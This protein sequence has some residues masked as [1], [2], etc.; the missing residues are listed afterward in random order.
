MVLVANNED[1]KILLLL[2]ICDLKELYQALFF[3]VISFINREVK[4]K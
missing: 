4:E 1:K 2:K 3:I